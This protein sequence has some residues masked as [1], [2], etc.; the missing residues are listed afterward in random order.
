MELYETKK[1]GENPLL[2]ND[3]IL[4]LVNLIQNI[5]L[6]FTFSKPAK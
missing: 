2:F 3:T 6:N 5:N 4:L 1:A